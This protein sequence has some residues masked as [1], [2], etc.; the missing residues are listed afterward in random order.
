MCSDRQNESNSPLCSE[1]LA[2]K[3]DESF[4]PHLPAVMTFGTTNS[5][6]KQHSAIWFF[7]QLSLEPQHYTRILKGKCIFRLAFLIVPTRVYIYF[8]LFAHVFFSASFKH[9]SWQG[10]L[11]VWNKVYSWKQRVCVLW[12]SMTSLCEYHIASV[13]YNLPQPV[14]QKSVM[15]TP[16]V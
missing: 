2:H 5:A 7:D 11:F 6:R 16:K 15:K 9:C 13:P 8:A 12:R 1:W 3:D 14:K 10:E 4:L